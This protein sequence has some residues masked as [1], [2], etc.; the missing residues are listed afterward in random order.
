MVQ[1]TER[2]L[3]MLEMNRSR[4]RI[5]VRVQDAI[6]KEAVAQKSNEEVQTWE[7]QVQSLSSKVGSSAGQTPGTATLGA[8]R[9][10]LGTLRRKSIWASGEAGSTRMWLSVRNGSKELKPNAQGYTVN[11]LGDFIQ[12]SPSWGLHVGGGFTALPLLLPH[13]RWTTYSDSHPLLLF[14]CRE[15]FWS[16]WGLCCLW[17]T[18]QVSWPPGSQGT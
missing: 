9:A 17:G 14:I 10:H 15:M 4:V 1:I 2:V 11:I 16:S 6:L 12:I 8:L 18:E 7:T 3:V 13:S 5:R